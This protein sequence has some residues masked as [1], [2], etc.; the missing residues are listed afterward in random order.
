MARQAFSREFNQVRPIV[1]TALGGAA[2]TTFAA[3]TGLFKFRAPFTFK[4]VGASLNV[5]ARGG[6]HSTS[7]LD[8]KAGGVSMLASTFNVASLTPGTIVDKEGDAAFSATGLNVAKD[9][10][11]T[12]ET[13]QSGGTSPTWGDVTLQ[14]DV[15]PLGD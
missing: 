11:I 9:A 5:H 8:V 2:L 7:T 14:L 1:L 4:L 3:N 6:T 12:V 13:A 15:V 10:V